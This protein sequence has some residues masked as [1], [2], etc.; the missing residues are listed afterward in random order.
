MTMIRNLNRIYTNNNFPNC[1]FALEQHK[2]TTLVLSNYQSI[3]QYFE[4]PKMTWLHLG[5]VTVLQVCPFLCFFPFQ[6][7]MFQPFRLSLYHLC[8]VFKNFVTTNLRVLYR[9]K[10]KCPNY[11][12]RKN[13]KL[14]FN[15][16]V[17]NAY[18]HILYIH[19][20]LIFSSST[21][22][23]FWGRCIIFLLLS[24]EKRSIKSTN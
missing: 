13:Y 1:K 19:I 16:V 12:L 8:Y 21:F 14:C 15:V 22:F 11:I 18:T 9:G 24:K 6:G 2:R 4:L 3:S 23:Y 5:L 7:M 17:Y 20:I 10:K